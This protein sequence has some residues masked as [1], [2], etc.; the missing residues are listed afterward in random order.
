MIAAYQV[1]IEVET[2]I[3][4]YEHRASAQLQ[5]VERALIAITSPFNINVARGGSR[6]IPKFANYP[7]STLLSRKPSSSTSNDITA[8]RLRAHL[9]DGLRI[10]RTL[11]NE[12]LNSNLA[13]PSTARV[14]QALL[15]DHVGPPAGRTPALQ[16]SSDI[17]LE[18]LEARHDEIEY[19]GRLAG[20]GPSLACRARMAALGLSSSEIEDVY[21]SNGV[22]KLIGPFTDV[23]PLSVKHE[24]LWLEILLLTKT[25]RIARPSIIRAEGKE[26]AALLA[27]DAL[28]NAFPETP[29]TS[30][31][32]GIACF[33]EATVGLDAEML[34]QLVRPTVMAL[35]YESL[36]PQDFLPW[37]GQSFISRIG[38]DL[39]NDLALVIPNVSP[40][41]AVR[42]RLIVTVSLGMC[43][44]Q[45]EDREGNNQ[46]H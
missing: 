4:T 39:Q 37:V 32:L 17:T 9:E 13:A 7:R 25:L 36:G 14:M 40:L 12:D 35:E 22:R 1:I 18:A 24:A 3:S 10:R 6:H 11:N 42:S 33:F 2:N 45:S 46:S 15:A 23:Y 16:I 38:P 8:E 41:I 20:P 30:Q 34:Q 26:A 21:A 43:Q 31:Q 28:N 5:A 27:R 44:I 19:T 29:T